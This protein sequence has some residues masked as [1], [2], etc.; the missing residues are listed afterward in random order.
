MTRWVTR[1]PLVTFRV[2][3]CTVCNSGRRRGG[4]VGRSKTL[5]YSIRAFREIL[6]VLGHSRP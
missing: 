1:N 6:T 2:G 5:N 3:G 4:R